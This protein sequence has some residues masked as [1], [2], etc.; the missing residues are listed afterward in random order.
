M[1]VAY[2]PDTGQG[3]IEK[4][5]QWI[6]LSSDNI[7]VSETTGEVLLWDEN[8]WVSAYVP[9]V[10]PEEFEQEGGYYGNVTGD[11]DAPK[12]VS[13]NVGEPINTD[14]SG[15]KYEGVLGF[16]KESF[17]KKCSRFN[18]SKRKCC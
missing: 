11:S 3:I 4:N 14:Y 15:E 17:E 6:P 1:S 12:T 16:L 13:L 5:N 9:P 10:D 7:A 8:K 18:T 2:N